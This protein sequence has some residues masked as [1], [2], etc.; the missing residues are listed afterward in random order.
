MLF[1]GMSERRRPLIGFVRRDTREGIALI[2]FSFCGHMKV[3]AQREVVGGVQRPESSPQQAPR[4][5][6]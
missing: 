6:R 3:R 1:E 2:F 4:R 5:E